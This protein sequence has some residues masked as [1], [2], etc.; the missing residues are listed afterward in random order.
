LARAKPVRFSRLLPCFRASLARFTAAVARMICRALRSGVARWMS[1][2]VRAEQMRSEPFVLGLRLGELDGSA[3]L[4]V[5]ERALRSALV[6]LHTDR[7]VEAL[8]RRH[9][10]VGAIAASPRWERGGGR[11]QTHVRHA[12]SRRSRANSRQRAQRASARGGASACCRGNIPR[13]TALFVAVSSQRYPRNKYANR[14]P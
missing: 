7:S 14:A 10:G 1:R 8:W 13:M 3:T 11:A 12:P 5:G 6:S 9:H 2:D 4:T